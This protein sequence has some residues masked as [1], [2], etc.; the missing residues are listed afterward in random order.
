MVLSGESRNERQN[1]ESA[2]EQ[3][4]KLSSFTHP[5]PFQQKPPAMQNMQARRRAI[6]FCI[7]VFV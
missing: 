2:R 4:A 3:A 1:Y 6:V 5:A 7:K